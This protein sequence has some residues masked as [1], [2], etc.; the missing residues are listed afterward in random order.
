MAAERT[1]Q[2]PLALVVLAFLSERPMHAYLM[3][4]LM[5]QRDKGSIVSLAQ[6]NSLYQAMN[7]LVKSGLAEVDSTERSDNRPER[8]V[9]RIT[10][11][12]TTALHRWTLE[13]LRDE[14]PEFPSMPVAISLMM[15][16]SPDEV[17]G[18]LAARL[19]LLEKAR[20]ALV[21]SLATASGMGLPRLFVLDE[22][23]RRAVLDAQIVWLTAL[24]ADLA[25]GE[26]TWSAKWIAEVAKAFE[27]S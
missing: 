26:I 15:L 21:V 18:A 11:A 3:F 6:R 27:P 22:D 1:R 13:L 14:T 17:Q 12:G 24:L 2:S 19:A 5:Q 7:R 16:L 25:S 23:Y 8:T 10:D 20:D 9:Y 4:Q